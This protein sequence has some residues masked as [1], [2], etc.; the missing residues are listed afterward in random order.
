MGKSS[1]SKIV[2]T[3]IHGIPI[4]EAIKKPDG[5]YSLKIKRPKGQ[6]VEEVA[7]DQ[8]FSMVMNEAEKEPAAS[9]R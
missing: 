9:P 7:L 3:P 4:G 6:E 5:H 1:Q 8:L 2:R